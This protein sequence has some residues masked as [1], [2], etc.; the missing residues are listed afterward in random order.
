MSGGYTH[1]TLIQ[2]AMEEALHRRGDLLH[3]EARQALGLWKKF[4]I[5]G[6][7]APDYPY[8]DVLHSTS[9]PWADAMHKGQAIEVMRRSIAAVR[10]MS[11]ARRR[12]KCMAWLFGFA[13]HM[14]TDG[15]IHPVVNLKVGPYEQNKTEHR[16]CEMSQDVYAHKRLNLGA[17]ECNHQVSTNILD[18]S[19][20]N[21][22]ELLDADIA[23][24]WRDAL[25][26]TY[27][28]LGTPEVH[29]WHKAMRRMMN[30]GES[31]DVLFPFA[32]HVAT[33]LGL[34]YPAKPEATYIEQLA[35]PGQQTL[36]FEAIFQKALDNMVVMWGWMALSLQ[37][38]P[39]PLDTLKSMSLD[40]GLDTDNHMVYWS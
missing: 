28:H 4:C 31:G 36:H 2:L 23:T 9:P 40:T 33:N 18:C 14:S 34:V 25:T 27:P 15:T 26:A 13:S 21:D 20:S 30:I 37:N 39:S 35:V 6:S 7:V 19:D 3:P 29:A 10:T 32:R 1:V 8:L 12:Q 11:D 17:L 24:L 5:V 22:A 38:R 16:R